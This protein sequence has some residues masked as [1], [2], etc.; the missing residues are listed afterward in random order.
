MKTFFVVLF[1]ARENGY[2]YSSLGNYCYKTED[3]ARTY[4]QQ[5]LEIS[6]TFSAFVINSVMLS[7]E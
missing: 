4:A 3:E 1:K 2:E 6:D 5:F 7:H